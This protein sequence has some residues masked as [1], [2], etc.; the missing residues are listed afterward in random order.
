MN[1]QVNRRNF[2]KLSATAGAALAL[3]PAGIQAKET[4]MNKKKIPVR[5]LGKRTGIKLPVLSMGVMN[6]DNTSVVR[7]AYNSGILLF[8][9]AN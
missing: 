1:K 3:V 8:D 4:D 2:L 5:T 9:T 6:A 7:A